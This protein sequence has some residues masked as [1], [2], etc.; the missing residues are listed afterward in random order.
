MSLPRRQFLKTGAAGLAGFGLLPL[1]AA[2]K[3]KK[4]AN[5]PAKGEIITR[6]L[7]RTGIRLPIVSMGVMNADNPALV[8]AAL[9]A[10][11]AHLDT[12]HVYQQGRNEEMIGGVIQDFPRQSFTIAT[13]VVAMPMD[14]TTGLFSAETKPGP[15]VEKFE[16][17]LKRLRLEYVDILYLHSVA[18]REAALFEPILGAM[19]K[20]KEQ[21]KTR[22]IGLSTHRNEPEVVRAAVEA[23]LYDVVLTAFNFRQEYREELRRAIA[24]ATAAGLGIVAMKTQAGVFFDK[25]KTR[26]INMKAAL[27]WALQDA[28]VHTAIPGFTTFEQMQE[29][30]SVMRDL[31]L[32]AAEQA[33]LF[34]PQQCAGLYCQQCGG[35]ERGCAQHLPIPELMRGFM[36]LYGY[37]NFQA[38]RQ[39]MEELDIPAGACAD[40]REC[41][42]VCRQ[43]FDIRARIAELHSLRNTPAAWFV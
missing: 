12:A 24:E 16:L 15:F 27:K 4:T 23:K 2:E 43:G 32:T 5:K 10:G 40:C 36:Y 35:C 26:P 8:R 1:P 37:R 39:Q 31:T 34:P 19:Q 22:F 20:L 11:I 9:Q 7:G 29:D 25:E 28:N 18:R 38:A 6:T 17:S 42:A 3:N 30:L 21:G 33:A 41:T 13:K 14:R